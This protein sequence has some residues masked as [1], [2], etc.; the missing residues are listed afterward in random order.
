ML[1]RSQDIRSLHLLCNFSSAIRHGS[2]W[3]LQETW[4][5]SFWYHFVACCRHWNT[6]LNHWE[7]PLDPHLQ[8]LSAVSSLSC[9]PESCALFCCDCFEVVSECD[10]F[11]TPVTLAGDTSSVM[12]SRPGIGDNFASKMFRVCWLRR[13]RPVPPHGLWDR[14]EDWAVDTTAWFRNAAGLVH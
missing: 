11:V 6:H 14:I 5:W 2:I 4:A 10:S 7:M 8:T 3:P 12:S 1:S 9:G 13:E